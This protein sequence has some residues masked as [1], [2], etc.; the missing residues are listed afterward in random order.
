MRNVGGAG[1]VCR[2]GERAGT[3]PG[4]VACDDDQGD[5]AG[6]WCWDVVVVDPQGHVVTTLKRDAFSIAED[7]LPQTIRNFEAPDAHGEPASAPVVHGSADLAKIGNAPVNVLVFDEVNTAFLSLAFARQQMEKYLRAQPET[8]PVPTLFVAVGAKRIG[9]LHD[10]TQSR[11]ELLASVKTHTADLD[12]TTVLA[13]LNG[14]SS[15]AEQGMVQTLGALEQIAASLR[16]ILGRKNVIWI[17]PGYRAAED[18]NKLLESDRGRVVDEVKTVTN[19]LLE[20]RVTLYV[21]DPQGVTQPAVGNGPDDNGD[22]GG[23][24]SLNLTAKTDRSEVSDGSISFEGF[25]TGTGGR[26]IGGRNDL[27]APAGAGVRRKARSTTPCLTFRGAPCQ[28]APTIRR[29]RSGASA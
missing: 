20:A 8:L 12:F 10:Y 11:A 2:G 22:A 27:D 16:G 5:L 23:A 18:L 6:W 19:R 28:Q 7:K 29:G 24:A 14:G 13:S 4:C 9:V 1:G 21:I 3:G 25:V 15:G 26:A 17:G